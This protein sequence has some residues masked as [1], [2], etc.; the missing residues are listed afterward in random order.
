MHVWDDRL[1][2]HHPFTVPL[3]DQVKQWANYAASILPKPRRKTLT[4][5]WIGINDTNDSTGNATVSSGGSIIIIIT[6]SRTSH[7]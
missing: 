3:V 5:W 4:A 6:I 7:R 1:P 2:L